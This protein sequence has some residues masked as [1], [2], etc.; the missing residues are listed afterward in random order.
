MTDLHPDHLRL[1]S[2]ARAAFKARDDR[3][4][5]RHNI[6]LAAGEHGV[7]CDQVWDELERQ[8]AAQDGR[9]PVAE[10]PAVKKRRMIA[11]LRSEI[12]ATAQNAIISAL[13]DL[14]RGPLLEDEE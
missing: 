6:D 1:L 9:V 14:R 11:Q 5:W 13:D 10:L 7:A 3:H 8:V 2:L 4:L 12:V